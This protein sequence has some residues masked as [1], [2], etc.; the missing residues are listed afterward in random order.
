MTTFD[1]TALADKAKELV[2]RFGRPITV[3]Q[4]DDAIDDPTKPWRGTANP[5]AVPTAEV[6]AAGVFVEPTGARA[7]G[8]S[9]QAG[10]LLKRSDAIF[11]VSLGSA[12]NGIDLSLFDEV[13][14]GGKRWKI[15]VVEKLQ[16]GDLTLL[17]F[18]GVK[19]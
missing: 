9:T 13:L 5:R 12:S 18:L 3:I 16:P 10:E 1:Y 7:L 6:Q 2:D 11:L 8:I 4:Y 15:E 19:R 17:Y 14:D